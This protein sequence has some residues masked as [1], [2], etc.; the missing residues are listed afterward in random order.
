GQAEPDGPAGEQPEDQAFRYHNSL[1]TLN[2]QGE[3]LGRYDKVKLV[4]FG[5]FLPF[6]SWLRPLG[7]DAI[8]AGSTDFT[9]GRPLDA[10]YLP[11][12]LPSH[13]PRPL[14]MV[15]YEVIFP[16]LFSRAMPAADWIVTVTNDAWFGATA[17][18]YQHFFSARMRAIETGL[19]VVR[20]ANTGISGVID[21]H[22]RVLV[23]T[24][25]NTSDVIDMALPKPARRSQDDLNAASRFT[26]LLFFYILLASWSLVATIAV[27]IARPKRV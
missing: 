9:P 17:G 13:L 24:A 7:V 26:P 23:Q 25:L 14:P 2:G 22:G 10:D 6:R 8:A 5:E 19:P 21:G 20:V 16:G 1:I 15:C 3:A 4:P 18:P 11:P 12:L 27:R